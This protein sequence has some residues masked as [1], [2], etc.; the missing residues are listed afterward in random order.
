M[1]VVVRAETSSDFEAI[2]AVVEA[3]FGKP[4]EAAIV[5][6]IRTSDGYVPH[7][8]LVAEDEG[9]IIGHTMLSRVGL[10]GSSRRLLQLAPTAVVPERQNEGVGVALG[11]AALEAADLSSE[12]LVLVLGQPPVLPALRVPSGLPTRSVSA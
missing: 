11:R 10:E 12:P 1:V 8:A 5:E 7:L 6:A 4:N 3:A 9:R 2:G